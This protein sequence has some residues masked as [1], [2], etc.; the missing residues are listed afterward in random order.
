MLMVAM[1][2]LSVTILLA[3]PAEVLGH[4]G[5]HGGGGGARGGGHYGGHYG[6]YAH[7]Y[8]HGYYG[9]HGRYGYG[10]RGYPYWRGW[11]GYP[12]GWGYPYWWNYW[13]GYPYWGG[14]LSYPYAY[15]YY[16]S[17]YY[18]GYG[19]PPVPPEGINPPAESGQQQPSYW[20]FCQ[21]PEGY[22]PYVKDCPGG[23][24]AVVPSKPN[25]PPPSTL[26]PRTK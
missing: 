24:M 20:H 17:Y 23:W 5:G 18:G 16:G 1:L 26:A 10:W 8:G 19:E 12:Y 22:Y 7:G 21:N 6:G 25:A 9:Y 11:G 4:S 2:I 13:W 14:Y 3:Q 15:P